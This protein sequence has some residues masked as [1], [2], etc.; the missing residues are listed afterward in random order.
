MGAELAT[1]DSV[2]KQLGEG[3]LWGVFAAV[4]AAS[5]APLARGK[6]VQ[7]TF[8]KNGKPEEFGL[9][10]AD[11]EMLN[12]RA[13]MMGFLTLLIPRGSPGRASSR[14]GPRIRLG[15]RSELHFHSGIYFNLHRYPFFQKKK[16]KS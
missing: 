9:F 15:L 16:K 12:G 7:E 8:L 11:A 3:G 2:F 4:T 1:H 10:N 13:A 6:S 14:A 5:F